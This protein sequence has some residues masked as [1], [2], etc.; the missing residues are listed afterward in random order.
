[1]G[2]IFDLCPADLATFKQYFEAGRMCCPYCETANAPR[3]AEP[4]PDEITTQRGKCFSCFATWCL[5]YVEHPDGT[6]TLLKVEGLEEDPP[7]DRPARYW[8]EGWRE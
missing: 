5:H 3:Y 6:R 2:Y 1:V 8:T 7:R 4:F